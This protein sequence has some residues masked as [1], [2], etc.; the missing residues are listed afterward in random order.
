MSSEPQA[1][2][3]AANAVSISASLVTSSCMVSLEP[4]D[5]ASG[6]TR[7]LNFSL[8]YEKASSAPSRCMAWAMPQAM[9]RSDATPTMSARFPLRKPMCIPNVELTKA[10]ILPA[11]PSRRGRNQCRRTLTV[12]FWPGRSVVCLLMPF[13]LT[14]SDTVTPNTLRDARQR[15]AAAHL[16]GNLARAARRRTASSPQRR[17][18]SARVSA[19]P[20]AC[21]QGPCRSGARASRRPCDCAWRCATASRRCA[22]RARRDDARLRPPWPS[23]RAA[24]S[25]TL[26][27]RLTTAVGHAQLAA[28][29]ERRAVLP[30]LFMSR[31]T[32]AWVLYFLAIEATDSPDFTL[33]RDTRTRSSWLSRSRFR[34]NASAVSRGSSRKCG[35]AGSVAQRWKPGLSSYTSSSVMPASSA[36]SV[37]SSWPPVSTLHEVGLVRNR[38]ERDAVVLGV[39]DQAAHGHAASARRRG[40]RPAGSG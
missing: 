15:V 11:P 12:S 23:T 36:A 30:R 10:G 9:E 14:R 19:R 5:S 38:A 33:C 28:D 22:P 1:C 21:R 27:G 13:Q 29:H 20:A 2:L 39:R 17:A 4:S 18:C 34:L 3:M 35:P 7:S 40:F 32:I 26:A 6:C 16:V 24:A 31:T 25:M 37:R 8:T